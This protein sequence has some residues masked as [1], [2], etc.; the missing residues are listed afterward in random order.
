[1]IINKCVMDLDFLLL[2]VKGRS[3]S[4]LFALIK[5]LTLELL[6]WQEHMKRSKGLACFF[7]K[8]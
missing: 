4:K 5:L 3:G 6:L 7:L 2:L 1:M 8:D